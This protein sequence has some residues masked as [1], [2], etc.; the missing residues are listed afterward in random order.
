LV[1]GLSSIEKRIVNQ[2][3]KI[4]DSQDSTKVN[5]VAPQ[6]RFWRALDEHVT[7]SYFLE[8]YCQLSAA[9]DRWGKAILAISSGGSLAIWAVFKE[10]P[11]LWSTI[12]VST[13]VIGVTGKF[14]PYAARSRAAS[15]SVHEYRQHQ[16][17]AEEKWCQVLNG[18]LTDAEINKFRAELQ[19]RAAKTLEKHFPIGGLPKDDKLF[20]KAEALSYQYLNHHFGEIENAE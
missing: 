11:L 6:M 5:E 2:Q 17:W 19:R 14:L 20:K 15:A 12:I 8:A 3:R 1:V 4:V 16:I 10:Y 13:Q 9:W 18:E 7:H